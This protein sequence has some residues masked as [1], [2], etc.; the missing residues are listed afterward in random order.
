MGRVHELPEAGQV[1]E[2][3]VG[4]TVGLL[5]DAPGAGS[6]LLSKALDD[7]VVLAI[8]ADT[9][10]EVGSRNA[11]VAAAFNRLV[12]LRRRRVERMFER[13]QDEVIEGD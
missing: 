8:D 3:G 12:T 11:E 2:L 6:R 13:R 5:G 10:A 1:A 7:C 4:E 9:A